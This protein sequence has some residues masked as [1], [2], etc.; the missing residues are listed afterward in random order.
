MVRQRF[1]VLFRRC[2]FTVMRFC[3][4]I[5]LFELL[6]LVWQHLGYVHLGMSD[7]LIGALVVSLLIALLCWL[8]AMGE[9]LWSRLRRLRGFLSE[10][11]QCS[12]S[13]WRPD[14][15]NTNKA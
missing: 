2:F 3:G 4:P 1:R 8:W 11:R 12:R 15:V 10:L 6:V 5:L 7:L 9:W 13:Y 14:A